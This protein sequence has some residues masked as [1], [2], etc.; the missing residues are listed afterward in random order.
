MQEAGILALPVAASSRVLP[1]LCPAGSEGPCGD[2]A[3]VMQE[4]RSLGWS[5]VEAGR[6]GG[7]RCGNRE[8]HTGTALSVMCCLGKGGSLEPQ[9]CLS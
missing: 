6:A 2:S 1:A 8:C 4:G 3:Q 7:E 9:S 5:W